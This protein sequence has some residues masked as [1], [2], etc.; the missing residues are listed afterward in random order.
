[1]YSYIFIVVLKF[2]LFFATESII[3]QFPYNVGKTI[4]FFLGVFLL[5]F[6]FGYLNMKVSLYCFKKPGESHKDEHTT[7]CWSFV[8]KKTI[9]E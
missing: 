9:N 1:M 7:N 6:G 8:E 3:W 4:I 5:L 2:F